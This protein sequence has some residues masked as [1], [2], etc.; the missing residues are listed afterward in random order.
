MLKKK[1][2]NFLTA[3]A[4]SWGYGVLTYLIFCVITGRNLFSS[5]ILNAISI[6]FIVIWE[7]IENYYTEPKTET[8]GKTIKPSA[9]IKSLYLFC[10]VVT[11]CTTLLTAEPELPFLSNF[12]DYFSSVSS[13]LL[14]LIA[15]DTFI[16]QLLKDMSNNKEVLGNSFLLKQTE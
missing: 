3:T 5:T 4:I 16:E 1:I 12:D 9:A 7:R 15:V 10:V 8:K 11:T 14:I 6:I 2:T 13:G